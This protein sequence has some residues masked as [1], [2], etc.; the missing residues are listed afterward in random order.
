MSDKPVAKKKVA[1]KKQ[2][3]PKQEEWK[4]DF[5]DGKPASL[6]SKVATGFEVQ[7]DGMHKLVGIKL[8]EVAKDV[9][10]SVLK[11]DSETKVKVVMALARAV[12]GEGTNS[13]EEI[14]PHASFNPVI[15]VLQG[16]KDKS[17][18][19]KNSVIEHN[20]KAE[21]EALEKKEEMMA[22]G[23]TA[24]KSSEAAAVKVAD[25]TTDMVRT[26]IE[27]IKGI[28]VTDEGFTLDASI[29]DMDVAQGF[30]LLSSMTKA[31]EDIGAKFALR[32]AQF[33]YAIEKIGR[34]WRNFFNPDEA[35][36][37]KDLSRIKQAVSALS[38][39]DAFGISLPGAQLTTIRTITE[40]RYN[41]ADPTDNI[42]RCKKVVD[43]CVAAY[44]KDGKYPPILAIR[45]I[46]NEYKV[47]PGNLRHK[48]IYV[49][50]GVDG[51]VNIYGL[52]EDNTGLH[53]LAVVVINPTAQS[54]IKKGADAVKI[55]TA[56]EAL[57]KEA[58]ALVTTPEAPELE[59]GDDGAIELEE[60][61]P[62]EAEE[63]STEDQEMVGEYEEDAEEGE[64]EEEDWS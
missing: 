46:V 27:G 44:K 20:T 22:V 37:A 50:V 33:A 53:E 5:G 55:P 35:D 60:E 1:A 30:S 64:E 18:A 21:R 23:Q 12:F 47:V 3:A 2:G 51:E 6:M 9:A 57:L 29:T 42:E 56:P 41:P 40:A 15:P 62:E 38:K 39:I 16:L 49:V 7:E 54:F 14:S 17:D 28:T 13:P 8:L 26:K 25:Q 58:K 48:W 59:L 45:G 32:E 61:E 19:F 11:T 63:M 43:I 4:A 34:D 52:P 31:S 10:A 36:Q 24:L